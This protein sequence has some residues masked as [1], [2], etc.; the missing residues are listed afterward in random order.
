MENS[1][2]VHIQTKRK[3]KKMEDR[4]L[5]THTEDKEI[6]KFESCSHTDEEKKV[7]KFESCSHTDA[8]DSLTLPTWPPRWKDGCKFEI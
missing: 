4:L 5:F 3:K 8:D 6:G 2:L 7:G 1:I